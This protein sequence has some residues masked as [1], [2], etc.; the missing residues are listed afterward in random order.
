[1]EHMGFVSLIPPL[2]AIVLAVLFRNVIISLFVGIF[3]GL[4]ILSGG[5]PIAA[6][7]GT[8]RDY[9]SPQLTDSYNAAVIVLLLF[10]GGFVSLVEHSGGGAALA[11]RTM[12]LIDTRVKTQVSAW[13][14]G[15][16]IFFSDMGTPLIVGPVFEKLFDKVK[17]SREKLAWVLDSTASPVAIMIPF[18][19]WGVY[20]MG[21]IREE[22]QRL[23]IDASEFTTF[24]QAIPFQFYAILTVLAVPVVALAGIDFGAMRRADRRVRDTG[25]LSW[26]ES[27]PLRKLEPQADAGAGESHPM[28]IW[29]PLLVLFVTLFGLLVSYGFPFESV[30]GSD[31]RVALSTGYLFAAVVLIGLMIRF[32]V[33]RLGEIFDTYIAG[34]QK[35]VN[36]VLILVLAWALGSLLGEMG[37]ARYIVELM[38]GSVPA[39]IV[40]AIIF[41]SAAVM[42]FATGS[43]WGTFAIMLPLAIPMALGLDAPMVVSIGAVL[44]GGIFGDHCS[45]ISD[46]TILASTGAG[47]DHIDHVRTQLPYSLTNAAIALVSFV[48]AG[49]TESGLTVL[50][51]V[52]LM[53]ATFAV[54]SRR[55]QRQA[56][57]AQGH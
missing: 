44:S 40:P 2:L 21:L 52:A 19:G 31:F 53:L 41:L 37:T 20:V 18:I 5:N 36:V 1:M 34:M 42:S 14:G 9:L 3:T 29:L 45:P 8:I 28:L 50:A 11:R 6:T 35:M 49:I 33:K 4:M 30:P 15:L 12:H 17:V 26:P 48:V 39:F 13:L 16:I 46:S 54:L 24:V 47:C 43:S 57:L 38:E 10:I 55:Q 7:T 23:G 22:F 27:K 32:K 56:A 51:S 25:A